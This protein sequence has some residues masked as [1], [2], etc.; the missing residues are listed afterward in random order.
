MRIRI[1]C[2][3]LLAVILAASGLGQTAPPA[4]SGQD[5]IGYKSAA[6]A[7][8]KKTLLLEDFKPVPILHTQAQPVPRAKYV[9]DP[10]AGWGRQCPEYH[11]HG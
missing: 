3:G 2:K 8:E 7:E 11:S 4:L 5:P 9:F 10:A 6:R 1:G